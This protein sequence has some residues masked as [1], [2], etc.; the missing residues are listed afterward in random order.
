MDFYWA[1][2]EDEARMEQNALVDL[3]KTK[4][5][6]FDFARFSVGLAIG[7][8]YDENTKTAIASCVLFDK[9]GKMMGEIASA[10]VEVD[11]PYV[12]GLLAFRV[13]PAICVAVD[14][15]CDKADLFLFDGQG[16]AHPGGF[17]LA[18]HIGVLF[19]KPSVGVTKKSLFGN[20]FVPS[21]SAYC[22]HLRHPRTKET[23]GYCV[24]SERERESFFMSPGHQV[25]LPE[26]IAIIKA[27]A[28]DGEMP[29]PIRSVHKHA[30][31][32]ADECWKKRITT[33]DRR[34]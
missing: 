13:G 9:H 29:Y 11:F 31:R 21:G 17:G 3:V 30:N 26:S 15:L 27:I 12:P 19:D 2:N 1:K 16:I 10:E 7:T 20:Y 14:S 18:S 24:S 8:A 5:T 34:S 25:S 23:I 22:T 6:D 32:L 28:G 4:K 33:E